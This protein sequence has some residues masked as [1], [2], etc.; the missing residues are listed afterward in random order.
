MMSK[1]MKMVCAVAG[2]MCAVGLVLA[3]IG[4]VLSGFDPEVFSTRIDPEAGVVV[5]GG[6]PVDDP[7]GLPFI[8]ITDGGSREG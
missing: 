8:S 4:F 3:G 2:G 1:A 6:T 5:I 7:S